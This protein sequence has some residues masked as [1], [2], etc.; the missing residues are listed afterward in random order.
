MKASLKN[1]MLAASIF[2]L[3][4]TAAHATTL[5]DAVQTALENHPDVQIANENVNAVKQEWKQAKAGYLP[6]LDLTMGSGHERSNNVTSRTRSDRANNE[7][8]HRSL[9][10][11]ESRLTMSQMVFDGFETSSR[12]CR[13][14]ARYSAAKHDMHDTQQQV[15]LRT[16]QAYL[17]V[18]RTQEILSI[19]Q[20][21]LNSHKK[22]LNQIKKR[23]QGGRG[24]K[25]D[26]RQAEG[27]LALSRAN[28]LSARGD[29]RN[30][31]ADYMEVVGAEAKALKKVQTPKKALPAK[32]EEAVARAMENNHGI[33]AAQSEVNAS[34]AAVRES[35]AA[36]YP[37]LDLDLEA[38]RNQN[39]DA[40]PGANNEYLAMA[41]VSY[42][43]YSGGADM[44]RK[45]EQMARSV[46]AKETLNRENRLTE[47]NMYVAWNDY[48][49][50]KARVTPLALHVKSSEQTRTAYQ[51][52]FDLGQ[53]SLLDLLDTE[54]EVFNARTSL[55]NGQYDA[56]SA[57]FEVLA[58]SG[59][60]VET[61]STK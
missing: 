37:R 60:L 40:Q 41:R 48:E 23:S 51:S 57:A 33:M 7:G 9:W 28:Y 25:A 16:V 2:C 53:R 24:S 3:M 55:I 50:A 10:R 44:A 26:V 30:A 11:N 39:L 35:K 6:S 36:F 19:A 58:E 18:L 43:L 45:R 29:F 5:T 12:V 54:I 61:L 8:G 14:N 15:A 49:T 21:N 32:L 46:E 42:N 52:Q 59:D 38:A 31:K 27:R 22:Y 47:E 17:D 56:K 4:G 1:S 34:T 20:K 13:N